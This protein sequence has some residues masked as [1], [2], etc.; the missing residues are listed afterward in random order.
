MTLGLLQ[1]KVETLQ[2]FCQD[3]LCFNLQNQEQLVNRERFRAVVVVLVV[4]EVV[5]LVVTT[6]AAVL[7]V[8]TLL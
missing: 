7:V 6:T 5:L 8:V 3:H 4:V 2:Q 1:S